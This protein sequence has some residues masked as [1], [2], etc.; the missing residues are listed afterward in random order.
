M[1]GEDKS[2]SV[3]NANY[4]YAVGLYIVFLGVHRIAKYFT[5]IP[6]SLFF[7][8]YAEMHRKTFVNYPRH[9]FFAYVERTSNFSSGTHSIFTNKMVADRFGSLTVW[10][11]R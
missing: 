4:S 3:S 1:P 9:H 7:E 11:M 6:D 2:G 10:I 5:S 8:K